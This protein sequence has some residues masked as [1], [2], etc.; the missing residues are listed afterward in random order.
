LIDLIAY[1]KPAKSSH[2]KIIK[3]FCPTVMVAIVDA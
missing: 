2:F 3:P 1:C